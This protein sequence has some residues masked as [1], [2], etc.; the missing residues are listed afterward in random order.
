MI[1]KSPQYLEANTD[2]LRRDYL[3]STYTGDFIDLKNEILTSKNRQIQR[4]IRKYLNE[5][6]ESGMMT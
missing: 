6:N 4:E 3:A 2:S 5:R 1:E